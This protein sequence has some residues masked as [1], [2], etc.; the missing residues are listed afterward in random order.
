MPSL[1]AQG[2]TLI[3]LLVVIVIIAIL[4]AILFPVFARA[5]E[6][7]FQTNCLNNQRQIATSLLM[8]AQDHDELF[9]NSATVWVDLNLGAQVLT[10][11]TI[12]ADMVNAYGYN[13]GV[14][15]V[16]LG[17][18][19]FPADVALTADCRSVAKPV[20]LLSA[21]GD[22]DL[23]HDGKAVIS[24]T[25]GHVV[26]S[27][28]LKG[29][30]TIP[31]TLGLVADYRADIGASGAKWSDLGPNG[32]H[33][34]PLSNGSPPVITGDTIG[35]VPAMR[36]YKSVSYPL[37]VKLNGQTFSDSTMVIVCNRLNGHDNSVC[38]LDS[39]RMLITGGAPA[40]CYYSTGGTPN[41]VAANAWPNSFT[42]NT[43]VIWTATQ[44][45]DAVYMYMSNTQIMG[46]LTAYTNT[47]APVSST[48]VVGNEGEGN[49]LPSAN[50]DLLVS[51][52]IVYDHA[53]STGDFTTLVTYL[54]KQYRL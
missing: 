38:R 21:A 22:V 33:L 45:G 25:D 31:V 29:I 28:I 23:R 34:T 11:P 40:V 9:S 53:L 54:K 6:K 13:L 49:S 15:G 18:I 52:C 3:E 8:V 37:T 1:R 2:F 26:V 48:I 42:A 35:G 36:W 43:P 50:G 7:S 27:P 14:S 32:L 41:V 16:S 47:L 44:Q 10:C 30:G 24:Y 17:N 5:R 4:A 51:E 20:N 46:S 19:A 12:G 39:T